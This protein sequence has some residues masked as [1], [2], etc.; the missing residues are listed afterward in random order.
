MSKH[1]EVYQYTASKLEYL[2][3]IADTGKG[4]GMMANLRRGV[5][6][7]PD[8]IPELWGMI[9]D[10]M[11]EKLLGKNQISYAEWAVY[12]ALTL[13]AMHQQS[14]DRNMHQKDISV[15]QASAKLIK[16]EEDTERILKRLN[17]VVT[18]VSPEDL[19]YHLR[20]MVQLFRQE[21]ITLDYA[22]L[23]SE[24]YWFHREE[25]A[26]NIKLN[27]GRDFWRERNKKTSETEKKEND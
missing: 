9:F 3:S 27:W 10:R 8:E 21:E 25:S 20:S 22:R 19:A 26:Q 2:R 12:T 18:A 13:Y 6:R 4:R 11:P 5:S 1:D 24:L 15:G 14:S 23:A 7:K 16:N 17:L